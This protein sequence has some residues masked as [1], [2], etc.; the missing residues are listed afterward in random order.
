VM[1]VG[2]CRDAL[3]VNYSSRNALRTFGEKFF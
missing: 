1:L 3:T 2:T